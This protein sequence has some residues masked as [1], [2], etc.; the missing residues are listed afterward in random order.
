LSP[1]VKSTTPERTLAYAAGEKQAGGRHDWVP[2]PAQP[3]C[4]RPRDPE[5]LSDNVSQV[6][7]IVQFGEED[8]NAGQP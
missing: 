5:Y 1:L 2:S 8:I 3:S 6:R 4:I 7:K